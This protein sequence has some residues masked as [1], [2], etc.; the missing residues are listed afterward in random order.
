MQIYVRTAGKPEAAEAG[1]RNAMHEMDPT[2]VVDGLRTMQEE[3]DRIAADERALAILA[4][5]FSALALVLAGVGS[6]G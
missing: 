3:I 5:G 1:I 4:T 6:G 2:L